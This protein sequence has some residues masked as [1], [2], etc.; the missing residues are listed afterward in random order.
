MSFRV[1]EN[2]NNSIPFLVGYKQLKIPIIDDGGNP[3]WPE[4]FPIEKIHELEN[5]VGPRHFSAQM[6]LEY[7]DEE[8]IHLD[9]G[10]VQF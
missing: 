7:V 3:A 6:M 9:P 4:M 8:K 10:A 1:N 5:I 2:F